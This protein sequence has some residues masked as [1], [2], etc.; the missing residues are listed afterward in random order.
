MGSTFEV[1]CIYHRGSKSD[2]TWDLEDTSAETNKA[3]YRRNGS[4]RSTEGRANNGRS[5][6]KLNKEFG[7]KRSPFV[8]KWY[9]AI[10]GVSGYGN[11]KSSM[12]NAFCGLPHKLP[13]G[14]AVR[15]VET[16]TRVTSRDIWTLQ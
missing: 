1:P 7:L 4:G 14:A 9:V 12:I 16:I 5:R 10:A 11:L 3:K 6:V 2:L 13:D 8:D 15:T